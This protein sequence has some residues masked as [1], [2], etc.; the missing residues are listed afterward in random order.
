MNGLAHKQLV[1]E[2]LTPQS[3]ME[4]Q[5]SG[6]RHRRAGLAYRLL[7]A[8]RQ[9]R[10]HP[11]KR[12]KASWRHLP[13]MRRRI[14]RLRVAIAETSHPAW[15]Q[16]RAQ[17]DFSQFVTSMQPLVKK[18]QNCYGP[19]SWPERF[20]GRAQ[21][22]AKLALRRAIALWRKVGAARQG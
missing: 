1:L 17:R 19:P 21:W 20:Y 15:Q 9:R 4:S 2:S 8:Q 6:F 10:W 3:I 5:A 14:T 12:V 18:Y 16:A 22:E 11:P 13:R 7:L